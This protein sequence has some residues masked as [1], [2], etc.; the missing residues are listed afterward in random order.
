MWIVPPLDSR[1][2]ANLAP[3]L[4]APG[5][6]VPNGYTGSS[7]MASAS[8]AA[9]C[10]CVRPF[11]PKGYNCAGRGRESVRYVIDRQAIV[12]DSTLYTS[13]RGKVRHVDKLR[14]RSGK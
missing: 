11:T 1:Y 9:R 6:P 4:L 2:A 13:Y 3:H 14:S 10:H 8:R 12:V 5:S 7:T